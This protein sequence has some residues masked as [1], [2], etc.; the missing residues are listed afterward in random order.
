[1]LTK[2]CANPLN[3]VYNAC[4]EAIEQCGFLFGSENQD[5]GVLTASSSPTI[6]S[7]GEDMVIRVQVPSHGKTKVIVESSPKA[8]LFDWGKSRENERRIIEYLD[9]ILR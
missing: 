5:K 4:K 6:F 3:E 8:Q 9:K 1:M 7:W 2:L